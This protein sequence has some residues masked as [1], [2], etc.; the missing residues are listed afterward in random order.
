MHSVLKEGHLTISARGTGSGFHHSEKEKTDG[1]LQGNSPC[2]SQ[3]AENKH[4]LLPWSCISLM[5]HAGFLTC[6]MS[7]T[8]VHGGICCSLLMLLIINNNEKRDLKLTYLLLKG[9]QVLSP[10]GGL[11]SP[12]RKHLFCRA[13]EVAGAASTSIAIKASTQ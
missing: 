9:W 2:K 10:V 11:Y 6:C 13:F 4:S 3:R 12:E 8:G 7:L 1:F 5:P